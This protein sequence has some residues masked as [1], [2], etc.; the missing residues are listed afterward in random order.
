MKTFRLWKIVA[1]G[2]V[3]S[4]LATS[5]RADEPQK[6]TAK[7]AEK[8]R[9][10]LKARA[11]LALAATRQE[12]PG[13][14]N[15]APVPR[16]IPEPMPAAKGFEW[17][18]AGVYDEFGKYLGPVKSPAKSPVPKAQPVAVPKAEAILDPDHTCDNCGATQTV[19]NQQAGGM[20]SHKCAE[21]G[22]EWWHSD[23]PA[24]VRY[25]LPAAASGCVN[26]SCAAPARGGWYPGKLLGR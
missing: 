7:P 14:V 6:T 11:A 23:P 18:G 13:F 17:K 1:V 10:E 4:L 2:L 22:L 5:V 16:M 3:L 12:S 9:L 26:G 15:L 25:T 8:T 24:T 21:C 20:H 19:V